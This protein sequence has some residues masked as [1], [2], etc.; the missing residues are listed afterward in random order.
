MCLR[1]FPDINSE[2]YFVIIFVILNI[3]SYVWVA[4]DGVLT[5]Y[6]IYWSL[7]IT[8]E[9]YILQITETYRLVSSVYYILT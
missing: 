7:I 3:L 6:W 9:N 8:T 1:S 5:G 4:I 2:S